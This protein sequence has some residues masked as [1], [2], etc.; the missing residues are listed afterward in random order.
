MLLTDDLRTTIPPELDVETSATAGW[1]GQQIH[2][3][4]AA[5]GNVFWWGTTEG[6]EGISSGVHPLAGLKA[7]EPG[8][9]FWIRYKGRHDIT[10]SV[11]SAAVVMG[12]VCDTWCSLVD[13]R[14]DPTHSVVD[15]RHEALLAELAAVPSKFVPVDP[16]FDADSRGSETILAVDEVEHFEPEELHAVLAANLGAPQIQIPETVRLGAKHLKKLRFGERVIEPLVV[17]FEEDSAT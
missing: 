4:I 15:V 6:N 10:R 9:N 1:T 5:W 8:L 2:R 13:P 16:S 12:S 11:F 7:P 3:Y 17:D 14:V